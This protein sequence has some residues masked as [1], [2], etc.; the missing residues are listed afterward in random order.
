MPSAVIAGNEVLQHHESDDRGGLDGTGSLGGR[1]GSAGALARAP[2]AGPTVLPVAGVHDPLDDLLDAPG[3][4]AIALLEGQRMIGRLEL[5][6][7]TRRPG[8]DMDGG[9]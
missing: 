2:L 4:H 8:A 6:E 7:R 9:L 5:H 1:R 3:V